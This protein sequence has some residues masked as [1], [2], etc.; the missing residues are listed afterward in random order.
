[1]EA[2]HPITLLM[3]GTLIAALAIVVALAVTF[4]RRR[5]NRHPMENVRERNIA[6][7]ADRQRPDIR[8]PS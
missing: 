8:D 6:A 4:F 5:S 7:E 2:G 1:M 3:F